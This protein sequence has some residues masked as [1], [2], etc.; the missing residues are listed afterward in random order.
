MFGLFVAHRSGLK[1]Q[2]PTELLWFANFGTA[3]K[4]GPHNRRAATCAAAFLTASMRIFAHKVMG[5]KRRLATCKFQLV[6][7]RSSC[8][9]EH[10]GE[11][12]IA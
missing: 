10:C 5:R 1:E 2:T 12:Q 8:V 11:K 6:Y 4:A 3:K 7:V 9:G